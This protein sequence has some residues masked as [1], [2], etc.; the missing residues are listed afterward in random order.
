[1]NEIITIQ[2][3]PC[4]EENGI[5]YLNL[6]VCARGL[7]F[8]DSSKGTEYVRWERVNGY[9]NEIG[10][11]PQVAKDGYIPENI[12]Y[13][14]AMKAKNEVAEKFQALIADEVIP[15]IRK[16][17]MY[18]A[19]RTLEAMLADPDTMIK[20]LQALKA[21]RE[22]RIALETQVAQKDQLIGELKP[23]ADYTDWILKNPGLVTIT[24]IAKDYGMSGQEMNEK[25]A[26]LHVQYKQS[27]QWL[28][29]CEHHGKGYTHSETVTITRKNGQ[30]DVKMNTKWTQKGRLFIYALLKKKLG[31]LPII[32]RQRIA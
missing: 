7:G 21:E 13:R 2:N 18:A 10:F 22:Q 27:D 24:Q 6:E 5:A 23:K 16:H 20:T 14:L 29:Y 30:Q 8:V 28:L 9:L 4:F 15:S 1:M 11:S 19:P 12:F 26:S 31:L 3:I 25:L 17:G 32:E